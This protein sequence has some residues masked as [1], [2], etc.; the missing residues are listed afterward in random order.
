[1][2]WYVNCIHYGALR[3]YY[4]VCY[5][6]QVAVECSFTCQ[7]FVDWGTVLLSDRSFCRYGGSDCD[8]CTVTSGVAMYV[9][10]C[11]C[12]DNN[13]QLVTLLIMRR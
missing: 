3:V 13:K 2:N 5:T 4:R 1:M 7:Y 11:L 9:C 12:V 10:V 8:K 6:I